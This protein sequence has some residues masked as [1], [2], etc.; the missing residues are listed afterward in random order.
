MYADFAAIK[1]TN[2]FSVVIDKLGLKGTYKSDHQWRGPC[3]HCQAGGDRTLVIN[4]DQAWYC[5]H[6]KK[7][8]DVIALVAHVLGKRITEAAEWLSPGASA[9]S[10]ARESEKVAGNGTRTSQTFDRATYQA[11]FDRAHVLLKAVPEPLCARADLGVS[12]KGTHRGL[13]NVP[14]YDK[15]TGAFL[16]YAGV[17]SIELLNIK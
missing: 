3:P 9:R 12:N 4:E 5:W 13:I 1:A 10:P 14:L 7:G 8:G 11:N 15:D 16:C 6:A 17:P 2:P